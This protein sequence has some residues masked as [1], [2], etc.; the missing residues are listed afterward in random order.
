MIIYPKIDEKIKGIHSL[1][2]YID[3]YKGC[4][5][6]ML[7]I[8]YKNISLDYETPINMLK[9]IS[10]SIKEITINMPSDFSA[11]EYFFF[12]NISKTKKLIKEIVKYSNENKLKINI[13][14]TIRWNYQISESLTIKNIKEILKI[15]EN[16]KVMILLENVSYTEDEICTPLLIC[17]FINDKQL[18]VC[19]DF[20]HFNKIFK[21]N[22]EEHFKKYVPLKYKK[23]IY[24]IHL[25]DNDEYIKIINKQKLTKKI[26]IIS[27]KEEDY[28]NRIN[29]VKQLNN[30]EKKMKNE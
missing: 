17:D 11:I 29:Q 19:F 7:N 3:I 25:S 30:I 26:L 24:Q 28:S 13:L 4:E 18:K 5:L 27:T 16:T 8:D 14:F 6:K 23:Y 15:V 21:V 20:N 22:I 2:K 9:D 1:K 10:P 12:E